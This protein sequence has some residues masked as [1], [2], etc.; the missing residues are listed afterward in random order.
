MTN[1]KL[2][3]EEYQDLE[4]L[5][6]YHDRIANGYSEAD[7]MQSIYAR[8]RDN[9][10][11]PMH[12]SDSRNAGF[13]KGSP[14]LKV[15]PNYRTIN[16]EQE[17]ADPN[18]VFHYYQK[19]IKLRKQYDIFTEGQFHLLLENHQYIFAYER[20]YKNERLL[21]VCNFSNKPAE[22]PGNL[23]GD[24]PELLISNLSFSKS[25]HLDPYQSFMILN[26]LPE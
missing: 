26:H 18:S 9:A 4:T 17:L 1:I 22:F 19:L 21:V 25:T 12:W 6:L 5:N 15:N 16:A 23:L 8:S 14:W 7:V 3:I 11:T 2:P 20:I 24:S 10:R 13:S